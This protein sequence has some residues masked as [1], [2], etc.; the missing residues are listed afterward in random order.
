M[1]IHL[2]KGGSLHLLSHSHLTLIIPNANATVNNNLPTCMN[3]CFANTLRKS[4]LRLLRQCHVMQSH[5]DH[6]PSSSSS[7]RRLCMLSQ[8]LVL[9]SCSRSTIR[10]AFLSLRSSSSR[11]MH[12]FAKRT[13]LEVPPPP[14]L[15]PD[16]SP[17]M[18]L[19]SAS[20]RRGVHTPSRSTARIR[21]LHD[22]LARLHT[23]VQ[24]QRAE[25]MEKD[26]E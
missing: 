26:G 4:V 17:T 13:D 18:L 24:W 15:A 25:E 9:S 5:I 1:N 2:K 6:K 20:A 14:P 22:F 12:H 8:I 16:Y 21:H 23:V 10:S 3:M 19:P 11:F 7:S